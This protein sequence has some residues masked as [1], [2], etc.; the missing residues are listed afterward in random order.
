MFVSF[1]CGD[2]SLELITNENGKQIMTNTKIYCNVLGHR[3]MYFDY[4]L[5]F[6]VCFCLNINICKMRAV[7]FARHFCFTIIILILI[8]FVKWNSLTTEY[9]SHI[10][11]ANTQRSEMKTKAKKKLSEKRI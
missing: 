8:L 1:T 3:H 11:H 5:L 10:I 9:V 6:G 2:M 4:I 7:W